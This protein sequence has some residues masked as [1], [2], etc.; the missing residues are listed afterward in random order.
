M[1]E[2]QR[3][4]SEVVIKRDLFASIWKLLERNA[5]HSG[6]VRWQKVR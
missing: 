3:T 6:Y 1:Y 4:V 2:D 5:V